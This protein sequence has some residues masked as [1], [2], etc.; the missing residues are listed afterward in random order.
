[1]EKT[2]K[3]SVGPA[4]TSPHTPMLSVRFQ[5]PTLDCKR[6]ARLDWEK[7]LAGAILIFDVL[8]IHFA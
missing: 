5:T 7:W 3:Q 2:D 8:E 4:I 1:M 6:V